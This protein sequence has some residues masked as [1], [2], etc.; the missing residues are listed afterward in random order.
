MKRE[1]ITRKRQVSGCCPGHDTYPSEAYKSRKS[2]HALSR[3]K[4]KERQHA[5]TLAKRELRNESN[6]I[7]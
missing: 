3:S 2:V 6:S 7:Y 4:V 5:R 1:I